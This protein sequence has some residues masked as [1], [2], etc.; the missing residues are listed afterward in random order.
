MTKLRVKLRNGGSD[1]FIAIPDGVNPEAYLDVFLRRQDDFSGEWVQLTT[2]EYVR[3]D[4]ITSV[5]P[6]SDAMGVRRA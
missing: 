4:S 5:R 3:Y 1:E 6:P 2:G